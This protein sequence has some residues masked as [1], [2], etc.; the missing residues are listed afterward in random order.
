MKELLKPEI[1]YDRELKSFSMLNLS[2]D[3]LV[4]VELLQLSR[5]PEVSREFLRLS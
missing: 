2:K 3:D 5:Q 4:D 1:D